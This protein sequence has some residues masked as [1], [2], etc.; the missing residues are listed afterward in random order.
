MTSD[1]IIASAEQEEGLMLCSLPSFPSLE[2]SETY[3]WSVPFSTEE[4]TIRAETFFSS[5]SPL[6]TYS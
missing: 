5:T 1:L 3:S 6:L 2:H 4:E